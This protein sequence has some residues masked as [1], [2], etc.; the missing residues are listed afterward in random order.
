MWIIYNLIIHLYGDSISVAALFSSKAR[1]WVDGRKGLFQRIESAVGGRRL[2]VGGRRSVVSGRRLAVGLQDDSDKII[3]P[4]ADCQLPT[5]IWFHCAS[6][7]EFEQGRPVIEAFREGHPDWKILL[8]FFSPSGYEIR[9]NYEGADYI[10][11]LPLDT[12]GNARKFIRLVRPSIVVFVK[13][14]FWFHFLDILYKEKIPVYIISAIFRPQQHFF[15][16][17][18]GWTRKQLKK[19]T[20]FFVQDQVSEGLLR[21][22]G[23]ERVIVSGDTRFDRVAAIAGNT[24]S[25]PLVE[26]FVAQSTIFLAGSTWPADEELIVKLIEVYGDKMKFIIAPHEVHKARIEALR[27]KIPNSRFQIPNY[28]VKLFSALTEDNA[29]SCNLLIIDGIGYLSH[30]YQYATIAYIG[31]GFGVGIHNILE[32]AAFGK[33]VIFGPKFEKFREAVDLIEAGGA[34]PVNNSE[35]LNNRTIELMEDEV[36]RKKSSEICS[37]YVSRKKGATE[38]ILSNIFK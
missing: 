12:P 8:T 33:P 23:I 17:Y 16:W 5:L 3:L 35:Q 11:Y 21:A 34:F 2:A 22:Q 9:K 30:L 29:V 37:A 19:V 32:A 25:F 20:G 24:K 14:E 10:F 7:G 13:Y 38:I 28:Q 1:K 4:T 26:K 31:G 27:D 36:F 18:G 6:L 15:K